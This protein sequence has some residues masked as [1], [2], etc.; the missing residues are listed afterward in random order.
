M[1]HGAQ[2]L[3][4]HDSGAYTGDVSGRD[5][6]QA[7]LHVRRRRALG[8][9]RGPRRGRRAGQQQGARPRSGTGSCRSCASARG[10]RSARPATTSQHS[11]RQ[12]TAALAGVQRRAGADARDRLRAGVG[13][14]HRPGGQRGR[15]PG[16]VRRAAGGASAASYGEA[17]AAR[18][19]GALRRL[20]QGQQRRRDR[21]PS[22]MSTARWSAGPAWT[23]TS[24]PS[25]ARS[26]PAG[27]CPDRPLAPHRCGPEAVRRA[28]S[29]VISMR[30]TSMRDSARRE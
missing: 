15:R 20:G 19:A 9:P 14:R 11:T 27:P 1:V 2:D 28:V 5:A 18:C 25:S 10:W 16:G 7:G 26:P 21:R 22:P 3:S 13:D 4:P 12:L 29:R 24:S 30:T 17:V 6:G 23:P 8:A